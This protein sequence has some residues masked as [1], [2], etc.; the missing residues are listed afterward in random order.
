MKRMLSAAL[1]AAVLLLF[2]ACKSVP[3]PAPD[4]V[5]GKWKDSY[6]LTEYRFDSDGT[7]H[8]EALNLGSFKGT[9]QIDG[10]QITLEYRVVVKQVT[11]TYEFRVDGDTLYLND[12]EFHRKD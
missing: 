9:Y 2:T 11:E 6:G 1:L 12:R 5:V 4:S 10:S 3:A 8:L 7:M